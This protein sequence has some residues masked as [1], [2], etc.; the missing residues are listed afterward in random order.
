MKII[1]FNILTK[2]FSPQ[3]NFKINIKIE[4]NFKNY[5]KQKLFLLLYC[6][7]YYP[8]GALE[9]TIINYFERQRRTSP[10]STLPNKIA[11]KALGQV[12]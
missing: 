8:P 10:W 12:P 4:F 6:H 11:E 1:S 3:K 9:Y 7:H 5:L 2:R